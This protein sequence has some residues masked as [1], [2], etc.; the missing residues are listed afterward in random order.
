M[1]KS[2]LKSSNCRNACSEIFIVLTLICLTEHYLFKIWASE[3]AF[4]HSFIHSN[5]SYVCKHQKTNGDSD[6]EL[7]ADFVRILA[8]EAL[9]TNYSARV[10]MQSSIRKHRERALARISRSARWKQ[11][12]GWC[13]GF[14]DDYE[15]CD[16]SAEGDA[17]LVAGPLTHSSEAF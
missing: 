8:R 9:Q 17:C 13:C 5:C 6:E 11:A 4:I 12:P 14:M 2:E 7:L 15:V 10:N 3:L 16:G 1:S